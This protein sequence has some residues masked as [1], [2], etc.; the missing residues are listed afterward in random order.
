M[1]KTKENRINKANRNRDNFELSQTDSVLVGNPEAVRHKEQPIN[2]RIKTK[3]LNKKLLGNRNTNFHPR[4]ININFFQI[5][6]AIMLILEIEK[7]DT[8]ARYTVIKQN[9]TLLTDH[10]DKTIHVIDMEMI[11]DVISKLESDAKQNHDEE[12]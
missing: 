2:K 4:R 1:K 5:L 11:R 3:S 12:T 6:M 10:Y 8:N 7:L 9:E